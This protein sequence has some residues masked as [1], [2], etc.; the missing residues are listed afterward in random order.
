MKKLFFSVLLVTALLSTAVLSA[1]AAENVRVQA[2]KNVQIEAEAMAF[3]TDGS[4]HTAV[5]PVCGTNVTWTPVT[6]ADFTGASLSLAKGGHY[7]LA[8]SISKDDVNITVAASLSHISCL[9]LNGKSLTNTNGVVFTGTAGNLNVMGKGEVTG[10]GNKGEDRGATI[11]ISAGGTKG[12][13]SLYGGNYRK[14]VSD[15]TENVIS[16]RNNGG[17]INMYAGA[18]LYTGTKGRAVY[19]QSDMDYA[20]ATF[21]MY[22]GTIHAENSTER[23]IDAEAVADNR[24]SVLSINIY[25]G[26]ILGGPSSGN[27]MVRKNVV[28]NMYGGTIKDGC[29]STGGNIYISTGGTMNMYGGTVCGSRDENGNATGGKATSGG[30]IYLYYGATLNMYGG[31]VKDGTAT[32]E[33]GNI[34]ATGSA[35]D[36]YANILLQDATVSGGM[37]TGSGGNISVL[38]GNITIDGDTSILNGTSDGRGGNIRLYQGNLYMRDGLL[39]GGTSNYK[40]AYHEVW[41]GASEALKTKM[42][43]LGGVIDSKDNVLGAAIVVGSDCSLFFAGDATIVNHSTSNDSVYTDSGVIYICDGWS[44]AADARIVNY[45][46]AGGKFP[47]ANGK[48]VTLAENLTFTDGGSFTGDLTHHGLAVCQSGNGLAVASAVA[49]DESGK[50]T[51]ITD[52]LASGGHVQLHATTTIEDLGGK[53]LWVDLNGYKLTV[54]GSGKLH[55]YDTANDTYKAEKC[56]T[57]TNN[58]TVEIT[59][60][61]VA[62]NGNRYIAITNGNKTTMHRLNIR[63]T[64]VALRPTAAGIYYKSTYECDET[65][66]AQVEKYG[67]VL[68]VHNMPGADFASEEERE[69]VNCYTVSGEA[70]KSGVV[71]TSGS[72]F[73]IFKPERTAEVNQQ[74]GLVDIYA[75]PYIQL[76]NQ[77]IYM[78]DTKNAG[79]TVNSAD[80]DGVAL[81]LKSVMEVMD[82]IYYRYDRTV[83]EKMDTFLTSWQDSGINWRFANIAQSKGVDNSNLA[84]AEGTGAMCPV[85]Q[86]TVTWKPVT[87]AVYG[88]AA[89]GAVANGDHYYLAEDIVYTGEEAQ[90]IRAPGFGQPACLHLN[91][92]NLTAANNRVIMGYSGVLNVLGNG[93]VCG[94]NADENRGATVQINTSAAKGVVNLYGGTYI[95]PVGN[96]TASVIAVWNNGGRINLYEDVTVIGDGTNYAIYSGEATLTNTGLGIYGAKVVGGS[97]SVAVPDSDAGNSSTLEIGGN[98]LLEDVIVRSM[99]VKVTLSGAPVI[100]RLATVVKQ[101]MTLQDLGEGTDITVSTRGVFTAVNEKIAQ[102]ASWFHPWVATDKLT[103]T[104]DNTL[105]YDINYEQY[106]TP[107]VRDVSAEA[108]ADGKIH[109]YFMAGEGMIMSPTTSGELD[110]WGDSYLIVFPDGKTMFV[111]SGYEVQQPVLVGCLKRMGVKKLDYILVTHPHNDHV[112]GVFGNNAAFLDEIP[113][114][115][116]YHSGIN[117][118]GTGANATVVE[119]VCTARGIPC[120]ILE[121]GDELDFG[122][123]HMQVLWPLQGTS[124]KTISSGKINDNSMVFR[125]DY[126]EHS[127]LFTADLYE[128]G[129]GNL[130]KSVGTDILNTDFMKVPHHGW[131]TSSS[132]A[133]VN[134]VSPELAV[135]MGRVEMPDK[136]R[137]RYNAVGATLLFD[138]YNGYIHVEAGTD[139]TMTY[140]TSR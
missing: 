54:G 101:H 104:D 82:T 112:N 105:R 86:K 73:G 42:Y 5:C 137:K 38:R 61:V 3:P 114:D 60:D 20:N 63:V 65:L 55:A 92:H 128:A 94:N 72:V 107:Y 98:A 15:D 110:K 12:N 53:E 130:I 49:V 89:I 121:Q 140:E 26:E 68:S 23:T 87:Q 135:A 77:K 75:N 17:I 122:D 24:T 45:K 2:G 46:E 44:G 58:G 9:H 11:E 47:A 127:A 79:K 95:K 80:F 117:H 76:K 123:V 91:G 4:A 31:T 120:E 132:E 10:N 90:F 81:S 133:F 124:E 118:N 103:V 115:K 136:H 1:N 56:G 129:E 43:M 131:N 33:G 27:V 106:M 66:A 25:D 125:L 88:A 134:A 18:T 62:P 19:I 119:K 99:Y 59:A 111:D 30:N 67:V 93:T 7:Y 28:L 85:C 52:L 97:V 41:L 83:R 34:Y 78:G 8:E 6:G 109:Y 35:P 37:A 48:I 16:I 22:G 71:A 113:V 29:T 126:G 64:S 96:K 70:F 39:T 138:L 108:I 139:G 74:Y 21:N 50:K 84:F 51:A 36:G 40:N 116:V 100:Q 57:I 102:Y 14:M 13:I 69:D 32:G